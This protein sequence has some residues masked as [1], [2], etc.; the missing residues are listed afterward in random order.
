MWFVGR[1]VDFA[2]FIFSWVQNWVSLVYKGVSKRFRPS[3]LQREL[4]TVQFS[5]TR[6]S[7]IAILWVRLVGFVAI[8]LFVASQRVFIV[9]SVYFVIYSV[10]KLLG[11]QSYSQA[12]IT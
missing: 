5:A 4:Q 10:R 1:S 11:I 2:T 8:T 6:C 3:R 9:V 7:Y 12:M